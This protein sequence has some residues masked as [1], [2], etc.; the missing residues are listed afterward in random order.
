MNGVLSNNILL[1]VIK[2]QIP[3]HSIGIINIGKD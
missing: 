3:L 2:Y 1:L